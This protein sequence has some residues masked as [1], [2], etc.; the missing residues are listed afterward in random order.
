MSNGLFGFPS[1]AATQNR[2]FTKPTAGSRLNPSHSLASGLRARY[3]FNES[4]V[5]IQD[6]S[7][8]CYHLT[9]SG[10]WKRVQTPEGMAVNF[11]KATG[12]KGN[13]FV[14]SNLGITN[15]FTLW[16]RF[17]V[18]ALNA[19]GALMKLGA[20]NDG[21][22]FGIGDTTMDAAGN[23]LVALAE[24]V[25]WHPTTVTIT[26]EYLN[27]ALTANTIYN[28]DVIAK[29]S[30]YFS[31]PGNLFSV[32]GYTAIGAVERY[33]D[34]IVQSVGV[35]NRALTANELGLLE[36]NPYCDFA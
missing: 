28:R 2:G 21:I 30:V 34:C 20:N 8:N 6:Y 10:D 31:N 18:T 36:N 7:A 9:L 23:K 19:A 11:I 5:V 32:G 12:K 16:C 17:K 15:T 29:T 22:G 25:V 33:L 4:G 14:A 1:G 24:N 27:I 3:L 26:T 35:W 13:A